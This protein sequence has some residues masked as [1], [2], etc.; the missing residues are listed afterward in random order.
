MIFRQQHTKILTGFKTGGGYNITGIDEYF[1][2][3]AG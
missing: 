3:H 2:I 1:E